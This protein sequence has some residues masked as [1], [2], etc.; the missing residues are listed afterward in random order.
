MPLLTLVLFL[1]GVA[2]LIIGAELLVRGASRLA[3]AFGVSPLV[4]GLTVVALGT[5]A[6]ELAV[7]MR[8][9]FS[10]Q[11]DI[12]VGNIIGSNI[13][14]TLMIIGAAALVAPL[15][16]SEQLVR[17]DVPIMILASVVLLVVAADGEISRA[18]GGLLFSALVVYTFVLIRQSRRQTAAAR[19]RTGTPGPYAPRFAWLAHLALVSVGLTLLILGS[20]WLVEGA[21]TIAELFGVSQL[22]IGLTVVAIGTSMPEVATSVMAGMRGEREIAVGNVVGSNL[23]NILAVLGLSSLLSPVGIAV[24]SAAINFDMPVMVA[25]AAACLPIFFG[26]RIGR[27]EGLLFLCYYVA[28]VLYLILRAAQ[29]DALP[30]Y[31][32]VMGSF[33]LPLTVVS[34][35]L[36]LL[37][38]LGRRRAGQHGE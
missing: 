22:V 37:H 21:V 5:S 38:H 34:L 14:N 9:A 7:T 4:I 6:P 25:A 31:S 1:L 30:A 17:M 26:G 13:C 23:Y 8:A 29:H 35:V 18:D 33:V 20:R 24:A 36:I 16:V 10:G 28:Y 11:A 2:L 27:W 3:G 32:M 15:V 12:G 19:A